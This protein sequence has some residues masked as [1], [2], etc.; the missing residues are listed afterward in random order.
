MLAHG[1]ARHS[2]RPRSTARARRSYFGVY[3]VRDYPIELARTLT[4]GTTLHGLQ[5]TDPGAASC[6]PTTYYGADSGV[7]LALGSAQA[8][9]GARRADRRGRARGRHARL[10]PPA[11]AR[12]WTLLRDR[13]GGAR[14]F[15]RRH[16]HLP[17]PTARRD[18]P[19]GDRRCAARAGRGAAPGSFDLLAIDAFSSD[20]IPLHLMTDEAFD[21]YLRALAPDGIAA[22]PYLQPLSSISSRWWRRWRAS[23]GLA[24]A[25]RNDDP[26]DGAI[27]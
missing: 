24:A 9:F 16:V 6:E 22:G 12:R 4:H 19:D 8:L 18:A 25:M 5:S 17:R 14:L 20:A 13:P 23:G 11:R 27:D 10:L 21:V 26:S 3:T 7:G 1:G 2:R 15:A